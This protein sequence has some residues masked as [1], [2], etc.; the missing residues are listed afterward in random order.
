[1]S[2]HNVPLTAREQQEVDDEP[3]EPRPILMPGE[4]HSA[5]ARELA[6][7]RPADAER[8]GPSAR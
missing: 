7:P 8:V 2:S 1:M 4:W 6:Q 5:L 3:V